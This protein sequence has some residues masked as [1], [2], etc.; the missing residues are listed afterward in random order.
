MSE[1]TA[2]PKVTGYESHSGIWETWRLNVVFFD[3]SLAINIFGEQWM[4]W[5]STPYAVFFFHEFV[6]ELSQTMWPEAI[7]SENL[8]WKPIMSA[9][10]KPREGRTPVGR[11]CSSSNLSQVLDRY[12]F[13][14]MFGFSWA[15]YGKYGEFSSSLLLKFMF[16]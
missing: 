5:H 4:F 16:I 10:E 14:G 8:C 1:R 11:N 13:I 12:N 2:C 7:C 6:A 9:Q 15:N 3:D